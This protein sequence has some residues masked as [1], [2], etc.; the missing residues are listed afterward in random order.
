MNARLLTIRKEK[1]KSKKATFD[2][3]TVSSNKTSVQ[4]TRKRKNNDN[5][6]SITLIVS[7]SVNESIETISV[8]IMPI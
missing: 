8:D 3:G 1:T 6:S 7:T 2:T 4:S 5:I